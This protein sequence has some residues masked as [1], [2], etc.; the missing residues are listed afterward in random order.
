MSV[1]DTRNALVATMAPYSR[2]AIV[3]SLR[4]SASWPGANG[5]AILGSEIWAC[6]IDENIMQ[7]WPHEL[8][9]FHLVHLDDLPQHALRKVG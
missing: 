1:I 2:L 9:M 3:H 6:N 8:E 5:A 7:R 4:I